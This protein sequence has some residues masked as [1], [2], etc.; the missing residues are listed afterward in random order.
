MF[1]SAISVGEVA[2]WIV[3]VGAM[4]LFTI[5]GARRIRAQRRGRKR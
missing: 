1:S 5:N 2:E 4:T 3:I